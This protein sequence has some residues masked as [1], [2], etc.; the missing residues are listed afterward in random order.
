MKKH[1]KPYDPAEF[2]DTKEALAEY[3]R[4]VGEKAWRA[5]FN[6]AKLMDDKD[7]DDDTG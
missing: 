3:I 7:K 4:E 1:S 6:F 2:L 5:G